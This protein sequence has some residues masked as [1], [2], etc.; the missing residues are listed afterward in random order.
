M[1]IELLGNL[2]IG[3][4]IIAS[5]FIFMWINSDYKPDDNTSEKKK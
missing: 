2:F 3:A 4:A 1:S 5:G